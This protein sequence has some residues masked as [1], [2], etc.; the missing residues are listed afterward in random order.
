MTE[1]EC[2]LISAITNSANPAKATEI[3]INIMQRLIA[4][5]SPESIAVS[6]GIELQEVFP[7]RNT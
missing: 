6:Y 2:R 3:A 5:E 4:E 7:A 1:L